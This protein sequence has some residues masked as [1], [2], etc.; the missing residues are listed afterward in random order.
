MK[1]LFDFRQYQQS[2]K[3][4]I[5]RFVISLYKYMLMEDE[6]LEAYGLFTNKMEM[7]EMPRIIKERVRFV[8]LEKLGSDNEPA[9]FDPG[10]SDNKPGISEPGDFDFF[11]I[12]EFLTNLFE[13]YP[14]SV[15]TRCRDIVGV[16]HDFILIIFEKD[17]F[18]TEEP[19]RHYLN[20]MSQ[21]RYATHFFCNSDC[22]ARDSAK[23][24]KRPASDFTTIYGGVDED[25]FTSEASRPYLPAERENS[26]VYVSANDYRK[27]NEALISAF[28]SAL[29]SGRIPEDSK[30]F[31]SG[32]GVEAGIAEIKKATKKSGLKLGREVVV[33]GY[34]PD[35]DLCALI[36]R[37]R[38]SIFPSL[39]EGLGLPI[40]ESYALGTPCFS[41]NVSSTA[42]FT[43]P[44]ASF[45]PS[46][47]KDIETAIIRIFNE[48]DL[49]RAS[50]EFGRKLL[51][52]VNWTVAA[53]KTLQKLRELKASGSGKT[54]PRGG[55]TAVFLKQ[56]EWNDR[57]R[58]AKEHGVKEDMC[59]FFVDV[60][61]RDEY[62]TLLRE[63][64]NVFPAEFYDYANR[65][66][67]YGVQLFGKPKFEKD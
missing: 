51:K 5:G 46:D 34:I 24:L 12:G 15:V 13:V 35:A 10:G 31:L 53:Q 49:C 42:E 6:G 48:P 23:Y 54:T 28:G 30:L 52:K 58:I 25:V 66:E 17:Y 1:V 4:G 7:P 55:R 2:W 59:D 32:G 57:I 33:T 56:N 62:E 45:D 16:M 18:K 39:Y 65:V 40:L 60:K 8:E 20:R 21:A 47:I 27:N 64:S 50:L 43:L 3:R 14:R 36:S 9:V 37:S 63:A 61:K 26:I 29:K 38:A 22:T 67:M 41:S 44:E 11:F 19:R